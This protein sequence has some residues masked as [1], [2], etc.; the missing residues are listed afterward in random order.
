MSEEGQQA[1]VF[2]NVML[3]RDATLLEQGEFAVDVKSE[4]LKL[5]KEQEKSFPSRFWHLTTF[6][7]PAFGL[8]NLD[9]DTAN[10]IKAR[11]YTIILKY[12]RRPYFAMAR[13]DV[14]FAQKE[15]LK[16]YVDIQLSRAKN[17]AFLGFLERSTKEFNIVSNAPVQPTRRGLARFFGGAGR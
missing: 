1:D 11:V 6:R 3:A 7:D 17:G 13:D 5:I 2:E 14:L 12:Y 10:E 16:T 15:E 9:R 4:V 8:A